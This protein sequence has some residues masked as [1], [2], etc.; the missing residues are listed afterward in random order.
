MSP[1]SGWAGMRT[2]SCAVRGPLTSCDVL[3]C[4]NLGL[5]PTRVIAIDW[6]GKLKRSEDFIW[7]AVAEEGTLTE[8]EDGL[9][10][11]GIIKWLVD[12]ASRDPRFV[13]GFDFAFSF[14]ES[15][16]RSELGC[17][18]VGAV[19][20]SAERHGEGWLV[21]GPPF[22]GRTGPRPKDQAHPEYRRT[23][24]E[25]PGFHPKSVFQVGGAGHVGTGSIR[26]MPVLSRLRAEG[27]SIWPFH[28]P[29]W[30][31]VVEI[32]P[33][34]MTGPVKK[35]SRRARI[36]ALEGENGLTDVLR[37]RAACS[38]DGFDAAVSALR[39]AENVEE[40]EQLQPD[41]LYAIE[42]RIWRP[43]L[44]TAG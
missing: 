44:M 37:E 23:D 10:R 3:L 15:F 24:L 30:P 7:R 38:E 14:P 16:A 25:H 17:R 33:R 35:S 2:A 26:G 6:S 12:E 36:E 13:V 4:H 40:L 21:G 22:W 5:M 32:Y 11:E 29:G 43:G 1:T 34:L 18:D 28:S 42:G 41:P 19:W 27:F 31:R 39:M 20:E 8:L 9:N